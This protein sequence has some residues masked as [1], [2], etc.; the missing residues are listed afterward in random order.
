MLPTHKTE[1]SSPTGPYRGGRERSILDITLN[2]QSYGF[3][4]LYWEHPQ[5]KLPHWQMQ[6][7][8]KIIF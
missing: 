4:R 8:D 3:L 6:Y 5:L 7:K 2:P 1:P